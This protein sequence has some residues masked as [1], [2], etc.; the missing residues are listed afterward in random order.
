MGPSIGEIQCTACVYSLLYE[1]SL[2]FAIMY[3]NVFRIN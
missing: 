3:S 1:S 2:L